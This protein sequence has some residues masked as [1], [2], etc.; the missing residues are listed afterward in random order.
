MSNKLEEILKEFE[1][2]YNW[3]NRPEV[4]RDEARNFLKDKLTEYARSIVP[5]G[6]DPCITECHARIDED[7]TSLAEFQCTAKYT[8]QGK[9]PDVSI[10]S[11]NN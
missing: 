7:V 6:E 9:Q 11:S 4:A 1:L 2:K 8:L 10:I 3:G 5:V